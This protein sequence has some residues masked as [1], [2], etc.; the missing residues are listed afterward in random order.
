[1]TEMEENFLTDQLDPRL[2]FCTIEVDKSWDKTAE[3][4]RKEEEGQKKLLDKEKADIEERE[5]KGNLSD[6]EGE[7][8]DDDES[9]DKD[10]TLDE[11]QDG[12]AQKRKRSFVLSQSATTAD[13]PTKW[14]T[15]E[16]LPII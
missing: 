2:M 14:N 8:V 7:D 6:D 12:Q 16:C 4:R 10:F 11:G 3:Q 15:S 5:K 9:T 13:L 1:M